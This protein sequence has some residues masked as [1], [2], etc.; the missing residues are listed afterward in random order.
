VTQFHKMLFRALLY[1]DNT[2]CHFKN[3]VW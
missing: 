1:A 3:C 2:I